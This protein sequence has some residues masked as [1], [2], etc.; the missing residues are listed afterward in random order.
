MQLREHFGLP[1]STQ[2]GVGYPVAKLLGLLDL[3]TGMFISMLS[4]PLFMHD[5]NQ[6]TRLHSMLRSGDI[7]LGDRA[8]CSYAHVATQRRG[9]LRLLSPASAPQDDEE[10]RHRTLVARP[11][12]SGVDD[13]AAVA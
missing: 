10:A 4:L 11:E 12:A 2:V 9:R 5:M 8:F 13:A 1:P 3:A 7:L 6:V